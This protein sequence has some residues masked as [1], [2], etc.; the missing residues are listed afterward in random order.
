MSARS[1]VLTCCPAE[2][3]DQESGEHILTGR[4]QHTTQCVDPA[5]ALPFLHCA[6]REPVG[7]PEEGSRHVLLRALAPY[8]QGMLLKVSQPPKKPPNTQ[9][10][11]QVAPP[12]VQGA[13]LSGTGS[14][15]VH[16][17][18]GHVESQGGHLWGRVGAIGS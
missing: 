12:R 15:P 6:Y 4:S 17:N 10:S 16:E 1:R 8:L 18:V 3:Q 14:T 7:G 5:A 2:G 9:S 11:G 13:H